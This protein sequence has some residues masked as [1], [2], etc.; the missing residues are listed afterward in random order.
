MPAACLSAG[1]VVFKLDPPSSSGGAWTYTAL[2]TFTDGQVPAGGIVV[3]KDGRIYGTTINPANMQP[4][5][6]VYEIVP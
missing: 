3:T 1:G 4:G 2:H 6:T 5:G